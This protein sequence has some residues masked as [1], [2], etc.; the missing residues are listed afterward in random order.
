MNNSDATFIWLG[1]NY[2]IVLHSFLAD[3]ISARLWTSL[4]E[5][6]NGKSIGHPIDVGHEEQLFKGYQLS[7]IQFTTIN[8][9]GCRMES[10]HK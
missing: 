3:Y 8:L 9:S 5:Y 1:Q 2:G 6:Q 10:S 7:Q 4:L